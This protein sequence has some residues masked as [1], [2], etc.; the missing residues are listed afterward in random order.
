MI[1]TKYPSY[2]KL[3]HIRIF[4]EYTVGYPLI[5]LFD[6]N[7]VINKKFRTMKSSK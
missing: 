6:S 7:I 4:K 1:K 5:F 3:L 2:L